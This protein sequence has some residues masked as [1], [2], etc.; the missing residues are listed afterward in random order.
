MRRGCLPGDGA[1]EHTTERHTIDL[2]GLSSDPD[3]ATGELV[4]DDADPVG[5]QQNRFAPE[6]VDAP[7]AVLGVP[8]KG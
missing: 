2:T 3:D 4:D 1:D 5:L 7:E 6:Q 8:E